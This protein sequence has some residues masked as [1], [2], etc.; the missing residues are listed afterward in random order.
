MKKDY[1]GIQRIEPILR[2]FLRGYTSIHD[3]MP[4]LDTYDALFQELGL[5]RQ[6]SCLDVP[7][8]GDQRY[9]KVVPAT[10]WVPYCEGSPFGQLVFT[11]PYGRY[12]KGAAEI[13]IKVTH[14]FG[15]TSDPQKPVILEN[16]RLMEGEVALSLKEEVNVDGDRVSVISTSDLFHPDQLRELFKAGADWNGQTVAEFL[17]KEA[18][19]TS[20]LLH[21]K[22]FEIELDAPV[23]T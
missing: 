14:V 1:R 19:S 8:S 20:M 10:C 18:F 13:L 17:I 9:N 23:A 6:R 2:Y 22:D 5:K 4:G 15:V 12:D 3:E 16:N 11:F 7:I 21:V